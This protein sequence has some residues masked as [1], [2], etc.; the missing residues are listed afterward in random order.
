MYLTLT[1][2]FAS[3]L[4]C[5]FFFL[6]NVTLQ[7]IYLLG[8]LTTSCVSRVERKRRSPKIGGERKKSNKSEKGDQ[9]DE[10]E[11]TLHHEERWKRGTFLVYFV[12]FFTGILTFYNR[13]NVM[14]FSLFPCLCLCF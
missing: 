9:G 2:Q 10:E 1:S 3:V 14:R 12:Y 4:F 7:S 5:Y 11:K 13:D 8:L 6:T